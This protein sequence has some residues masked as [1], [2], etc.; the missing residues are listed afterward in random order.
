MLKTWF[1]EKDFSSTIKYSI[2]YILYST[3]FYKVSLKSEFSN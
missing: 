2:Y 1:P 3:Y